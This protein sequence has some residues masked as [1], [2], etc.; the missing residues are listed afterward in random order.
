MIDLASLRHVRYVLADNPAV[1]FYQANGLSI[2]VETRSLEL[3][4][5][6]GFPSE[7]RM[8]VTL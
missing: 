3:T 2:V 5:D 1:G 4:R 6:H 7:Y 8:A